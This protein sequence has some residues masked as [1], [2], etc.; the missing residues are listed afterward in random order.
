MII[1][2][3]DGNGMAK[4]ENNARLNIRL[5]WPCVA[6]RRSLPEYIR[7]AKFLHG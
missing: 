1:E 4:I 5:I 2:P 6:K 7:F 3:G